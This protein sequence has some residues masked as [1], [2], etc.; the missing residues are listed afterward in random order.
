MARV[1][2]ALAALHGG[3]SDE[4]QAADRWLQEW[5][6]TAGAW[7]DVDGLLS[8]DV[9]AVVHMTA[10]QVLR[11]KLRR[12]DPL[13]DAGAHALQQAV[14]S[15]Y[16]PRF[17]AGPRTVLTQLYLC[18]AALQAH[19]EA[20]GDVIADG[21]AALE[22]GGAG[23]VLDFLACVG[24]DAGDDLEA[25]DAGSAP[26]SSPRRAGGSSK[27]CAGDDSGA[28]RRSRLVAAAH[29]SAPSVV[30]LLQ[31]TGPTEPALRCLARWLRFCGGD[32]AAG[33]LVAS[34]LL[35]AAADSCHTDGGA[36]VLSEAAHL[37]ARLAAAASPHAAAL[38][39]PVIAGIPQVAAKLSAAQSPDL[40]LRLARV[41]GVAGCSYAR[42]LLDGSPAALGLVGALVAVTADAD[43]EA[44]AEALPFWPALAAQ[45]RALPE[46]QCRAAAAALRPRLLPELPTAFVRLA[47][48][49]D[50]DDGAWAEWRD[51]AVGA[52]L[53]AACDVAGCDAMLAP[54][55]AGLGDAAKAE[56]CVWCHSA[57]APSLVSAAPATQRGVLA[58]LF[59]ALPAVAAAGGHTA[60]ACVAA[61]AAYGWWLARDAAA[62]A[63]AVGFVVA[64]VRSADAVAAAAA[65]SSLRRLSSQCAAAVAADAGL[66]GHLI[67]GCMSAL[68]A[69]SP[70]QHSDRQ[71]VAA[72]AVALV[73]AAPAERRPEL[74]RAVA[75]EAV[76]LIAAAS[77]QC[78]PAGDHRGAVRAVE[79][80]SA[81]AD[82]AATRVGFDPQSQAACWAH[83]FDGAGLW[84]AVCAAVRDPVVG[85]AGCA[86]AGHTCRAGRAS[87]HAHASSVCEALVACFAAERPP[88]AL[89]AAAAVAA[90]TADPCVALAA[91][92]MAE[93]GRGAADDSPDVA[94]GLLR[95]A[96]ALRG[97]APA[98][99]AF[100]Y[101]LIVR[102]CAGAEAGVLLDA[103]WPPALAFAASVTPPRSAFAVEKAPL[104]F[105]ALCRCAVF[106]PHDSV[107]SRAGHLLH[108]VRAADAALH[109]ACVCA[110]ADGVAGAVADD[111]RHAAA[112]ALLSA[113]SAAA[114]ADALRSLRAHAVAAGLSRGPV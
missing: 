96:A 64:T 35:Q 86:A 79:L 61:V 18:A 68:R 30:A 50:C 104:L 73:C 113:P 42:A 74:C 7:R 63:A 103:V 83:A 14:L 62:L 82:A 101:D 39:S 29:A 19:P 71:S 43:A 5:Q 38:A 69:P 89:A 26:P 23:M 98:L 78:G 6:R 31:R 13:P 87:L 67:S 91:D 17:A 1:C 75:D 58:P 45:L 110:A 20:T 51:G 44:A 85:E 9:G 114:A 8:A 3:G 81:L 34:P 47:A 2:E 72:A 92:R 48:D 97:S 28:A 106:A 111:Q 40:R 32:A 60:A 84:S 10:A 99:T 107:G 33:M 15:S 37:S 80:C 90:L 22:P 46:P 88:A 105:A 66:C 95:L 12:H 59:A 102:L 76:A 16:L 41:L 55:A 27:P 77:A 24:E 112:A 54:A 25:I 65:A 108:S 11:S 36:D 4:R 93:A 56:A 109:A 57:A 21:V 70:L 52:A 49:G 94:C 53:A 100:A